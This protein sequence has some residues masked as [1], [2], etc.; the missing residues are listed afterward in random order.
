VEWRRDVERDHPLGTGGRH[1]LAGRRH[2]RVSARDHGL[3]RGIEVRG[4]D[5]AVHLGADPRDLGRVQTHDRGHCA[6]ACGNRFLHQ[7]PAPSHQPDRVRQRKPARSDQRRIL[8]KAVPREEQRLAGQAR[9]HD[10]PDRDR[11]GEDRGLRDL[12]AGELRF[13]PALEQLAQPAAEG[14]VGF[15][16]G[17]A[18]LGV[19]PH[20]V[21]RHADGL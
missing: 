1:S 15:V 6:L 11:R 20:E 19:R 9:L 13:R 14:R 21:H 8:T 12:G 3:D 4:R 7:R 18:R 5:H 10:A 2:R 17:G 16:D